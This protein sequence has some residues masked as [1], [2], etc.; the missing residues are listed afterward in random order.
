MKKT[1]KLMSLIFITLILL[2]GAIA[3]KSGSST[4]DENAVRTYADPATETTLQGISENSLEKYT[5][6]ANSQFKGAL[7]QETFNT[8]VTQINSQLG[9]YVSKQYLRTEED[10][11]YIIVHYEATF[12]KGKVGVRMVFDNN[13]LVAGQWFE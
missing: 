10:Q 11:G 9:N 6:N 4:I 7:T 8:L 5:Q 3:C 12:S 1:F 2:G 13:H